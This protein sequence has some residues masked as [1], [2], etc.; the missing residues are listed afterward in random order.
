VGRS[1][2]RFKRMSRP[3][4]KDVE[5]RVRPPPP[6]PR[7]ITPGKKEKEHTKP[8]NQT[9][10]PAAGSGHQALML[11]NE[12]GAARGGDEVFGLTH[13]DA[14]TKTKKRGE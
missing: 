12:Q 10:P 11:Q 3:K 8:V 2:F 9:L 4:S 5:H 6:A 14:E 1:A 13:G 7:G